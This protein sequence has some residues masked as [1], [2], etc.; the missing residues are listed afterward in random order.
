M[1]QG[2]VGGQ[3]EARD[4][5]EEVLRA[6][7]LA[8]VERVSLPPS[9]LSLSRSLALSPCLMHTLTLTWSL[10]LLL[11]AAQR[12]RPEAPFRSVSV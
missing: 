3:V 8:A 11:T 12:L 4:A 1:A 6:G 9:S 7:L 2:C 10:T 5:G